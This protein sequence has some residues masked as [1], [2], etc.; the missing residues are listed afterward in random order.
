[1]N[2]N[3][4]SCRTYE[5][6]FASPDI[7]RNKWQ[8]LHCKVNDKSLNFETQNYLSEVKIS[9]GID[10]CWTCF[11]QVPWCLFWLLAS[12]DQKQRQ[13]SFT[14]HIGAVAAGWLSGNLQGLQIWESFSSIMLFCLVS[15]RGYTEHP[16]L[17]KQGLTLIWYES[18]DFYFTEVKHNPLFQLDRYEK[19]WV[20]QT[21]FC[22]L[23]SG[24][25]LCVLEGITRQGREMANRT[26]RART[27]AA[28]RQIWC[29][30]SK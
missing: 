11:S 14:S 29:D 27:S 4:S 13:G 17:L 24:W 20:R 21:S 1:M 9:T 30:W 28:W 3:G 2:C 10:E 7:C 8:N 22:L 26:G 15:L 25:I 16:S 12:A 18:L 5:S 6:L 19:C 23:F